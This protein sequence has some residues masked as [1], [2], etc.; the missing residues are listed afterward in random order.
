MRPTVSRPLVAVGSI[1]IVT[2]GAGCGPA[3]TVVAPTAP[4][5]TIAI[6][7]RDYEFS[8]VTVSIDTGST[9]AFV[10]SGHA[11]HTAT[12]SGV[13]DTGEIGSGT[14]STQSFGT[15]GTYP[16]VCTYHPQ[17]TGTIV[18]RPAAAA[19]PTAGTPATPSASG[20]PTAA[21]TAGRFSVIL[22]QATD[23]TV[24]ADVIDWTG[25]VV[26]AGSGTPGDGAS[27]PAET[28][29][30]RNDDP[31]TLRLTWSGGPCDATDTVVLDAD[32]RTIT[33]VSAPCE[34]DAVAFDRVL[35][36]HLSN[37]L[38]AETIEP[39]FQAGADTTG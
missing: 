3:Q 4:A 30:V 7:V 5:G 37:P 9:V 14:L 36:L 8:P 23:H 38:D 17:M 20:G 13:F 21:P 33:V 1:L 6:D 29:V 32:A 11:P 34:G 31:R 35:V 26:A 2:A 15:P 18:V 25:V 12:S 16:F 19:E 22:D 28:A 10:N 24:I 39:R 27:V